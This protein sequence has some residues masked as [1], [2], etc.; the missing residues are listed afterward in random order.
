M[1]AMMIASLALW[2]SPLVRAALFLQMIFYGMAIVGW[3]LQRQDKT[4]RIFSFAFYFCL[5]NVASLVAC[6]KCLRGDLS[7]T[8]VPPRQ[9]ASSKA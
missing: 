7:G 6:L 1:L 8:W 9:K 2:K 4:W 3:I 5:V